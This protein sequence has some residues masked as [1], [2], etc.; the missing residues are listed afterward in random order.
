MTPLF[1]PSDKQRGF[2]KGTFMKKRTS[3]PNSKRRHAAQLL[4]ADWRARGLTPE[5][6]HTSTERNGIIVPFERLWLR[7]AL[8][9]EAPCATTMLS[10]RD[11]AQAA[12]CKTEI[13]ALLRDGGAT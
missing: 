9:R 7:L 13:I 8:E 3:K 10:S 11:W 6:E 5:V 12:Q 1:L 2:Q 4:I